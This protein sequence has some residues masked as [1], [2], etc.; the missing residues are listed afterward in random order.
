[1]ADG[2]ISI[3]IGARA[4]RSID[5]I[6]GTIPKK[7]EKARAGV[8]RALNS[9]GKDAFKGYESAAAKAANASVSAQTKAV[10]AVARLRE[11]E[12][13]K[14]EAQRIASERRVLAEQVKAAAAA[15]AA[16]QK[17]VA[18]TSAAERRAHAERQR[19][20]DRQVRSQV[21]LD[22]Q[23][24]LEQSRSARDYSRAE[25]AFSRR[26]G[27]HSVIRYSPGAMHR[28]ARV[29]ND[30]LRGAGVDFN[31]G[32][33]V[34]RNV[35]TEGLVRE[36][37]NQ[38]LLTG[39]TMST[40]EID[41]G[42]RANAIKS[43]FSSQQVA[44]GVIAFAKP[45][46]NAALG[47]KGA[48]QMLRRAVAGS[49]TPQEMMAL[50]GDIVANLG[51]DVKDKMG[52]ALGAVDAAIMQGG[53]GAIEISDLTKLF[54]TIGAAAGAF[55]GST[56]QNMINLGALTQLARKTG[57]ARNA[58]EA[59]TAVGRFRSQLTTSARVKQFKAAGVDIYSE[60]E[61]GKLRNPLAI[62]QDAITKT[63]GDP[64]KISKM[65]MSTVG[66]KPAEALRRKYVEERNAAV[67]G[68]ASPAEARARG[69]TAMKRS[70]D[71]LTNIEGIEAKIDQANKE[72]DGETQAKAQRFMTTLDGVTQKMMGSVLP[73][74]ERAGPSAIKVAEWLGKAAA[75]SAENPLKAVGIALAA[76]VARAGI[77]SGI[78]AAMEA[79]VKLWFDTLRNASGGPAVPGA[80]GPGGLTSAG[81]FV[82]QAQSVMIAGASVYVAAQQ[83]E[84]L[85]KEVGAESWLGLIPGFD[86][87]GEFQGMS[88]LWTDM[89]TGVGDLYTNKAN[90]NMDSTAREKARARGWNPAAPSSQQRPTATA[91]PQ[92]PQHVIIDQAVMT[93]AMNAALRSGEAKVH[94]MNLPPP[95]SGSALAPPEHGDG[96]RGRKL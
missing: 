49:T 60:S 24:R 12:E 64:L 84:A 10:L 45:T 96:G 55:E 80:G 40:E 41:R 27:Y 56:Q 70:I 58:A 20:I 26:L 36:I 74:L 42:V 78:R 7:A 5:T 51:D 8:E 71:D 82:M 81:K 9:S 72:R 37:R 75:W 62:L 79:N 47:M 11:R 19:N 69:A 2:H 50:V 83:A 90:E 92:S 85:K 39:G 76:S 44:E 66:I 6:F 88:R 1:M 73:S 4:D 33:S 21:A 30:M 59:V 18:A 35:E 52:A 48:P 3:L 34:R 28:G 46:G 54:P 17:A 86:G 22:R 63:D 16:Q 15:A 93:A 38:Q 61:P 25:A 32:E 43:G 23:R 13:R 31:L 14:T 89:N 94:V 53:K 65:L 77:E 87:K 57:G 91:A 68:G 67:A 29:A 95:G